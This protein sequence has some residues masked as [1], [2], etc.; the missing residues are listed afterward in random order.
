[1]ADTR[2]PEQK[3]MAALR[4]GKSNQVIP[5]IIYRV[6]CVKIVAFYVWGGIFLITPNDLQVLTQIL[7]HRFL[8]TCSAILGWNFS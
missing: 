3:L 1:M 2:S 5:R 7:T 4:R 6:D 8:Q